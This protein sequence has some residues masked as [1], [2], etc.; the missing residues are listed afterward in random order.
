MAGLHPRDLNFKNESNCAEQNHCRCARS[1]CN[2]PST[3]AESSIC[4]R[5][6]RTSGGHRLPFQPLMPPTGHHLIRP[7]RNSRKL[8]LGLDLELCQCLRNLHT[9]SQNYLCRR[10][11][12]KRPVPWHP[13]LYSRYLRR[14]DRRRPSDLNPCISRNFYR[15]F[16]VY[17]FSFR[18]TC[19]LSQELLMWQP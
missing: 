12:R 16:A 10:M 6:N 11:K 18:R 8:A 15:E 17:S 5:I 4:H 9:E 19:S 3:A 2:N 14:Q 7:N 1:S 13:K